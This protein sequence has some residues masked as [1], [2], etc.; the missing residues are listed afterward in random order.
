MG[1]LAKGGPPDLPVRFKV[2]G[3]IK[4]RR[5][6]YIKVGSEDRFQILQLAIFSLT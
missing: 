1:I 3:G 2:P 4:S 6:R 5:L